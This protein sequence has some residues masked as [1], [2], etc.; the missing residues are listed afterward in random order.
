MRKC[1]GNGLKILPTILIRAHRLVD[2]PPALLFRPRR[3]PV[4]LASLPGNLGLQL[5]IALPAFPIERPIQNRGLHSAA[6]FNTVPTIPKTTAPGQ[7]EDVVEGR[8][9]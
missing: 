8:I 7:F 1:W 5:L 4:N 9:E 2:F 6:I 3:V